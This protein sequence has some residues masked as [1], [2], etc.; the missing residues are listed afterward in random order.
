MTRAT[1][2]LLLAVVCLLV[3]ASAPAAE[4]LNVLLLYAD[5]WRH[6]T[7]G[8]A[9]HPVLRTPSLDRLASEGVRR[10]RAARST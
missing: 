4:P 10:R 6:D 1:A 3:T 5:D 8:A 9:G 7:L 2:P